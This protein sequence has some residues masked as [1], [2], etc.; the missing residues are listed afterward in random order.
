MSSIP[1]RTFFLA[2]PAA[3]VAAKTAAA[4]IVAAS[5]NEK[6]RIGIIGLGGQGKGH[7]NSYL[8]LSNVE[9]AYLCDVD[10]KH[11]AD[12]A[13]L[14]TGA[15]PVSDLRKI[16]DDKTIDAVSIATPDHWH[17]PAAL[18]AID[19]GKHV[20][21]EK[22]C[23]H[24]LREGR[25]L[26][27]AAARTG[28]RV[29]HG[30]QSR[31]SPFLIAAMQL[32]K[33][34]VIGDI[35]IARCWNVQ[36]RP[37]IGKAQ[38]STPPSGFDYDAWTGPAPHSPFQSNRHH[39]TWHWWYDF[40]TGDAGNDGVHELDIARWGLGVNEHPSQV[41]AIGGKYVHDDD[42]QFPDTLT[43][44]FEY[45]GNGATGQRKQLTFE[46]R[47]WTRNAPFGIDNGNEFLGTKGRMLLTKRGKVE[48]FGEKGEPIKVDLP[49]AKNV[50]LPPH[51]QNFLS[52]IR[53]EAK[54][55]ADAL[56]AHLS[57]SLP[58]LAN[59][60]CRAGRGFRFDPKLEAIV[61]DDEIS[62]L[63]ARTYREHW[64]T[65]AL[66]KTKAAS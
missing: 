12:A 29:Q 39:Y 57:S 44:A 51:H 31:S 41:T 50:A 30:T 15:K 56:T 43:A 7:L 40:G 1:R 13:K 60:A 45:P 17:T 6:I 27:E 38:P 18:L 26:V 3:I 23:S 49:E 48:V 42:Q 54:L 35:K 33:E 58:H 65:P 46:M 64:A 28:K 25:W 55:N 11:L 22:P 9:I 53:G 62:P 16:L 24:N 5:P 47:L 4:K 10:E 14:A 37:P 36:F 21:V 63:L 61:G 8:S 66:S 52:A 34:G 32:L 59:A 2:A 19:A 20:Y